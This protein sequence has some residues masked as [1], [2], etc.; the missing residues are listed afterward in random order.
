METAKNSWRKQ[1]NRKKER[2][3][4]TECTRR[5]KES[6]RYEEKRIEGEDQ[7]TKEMERRRE[8]EKKREKVKGK[9]ERRMGTGTEWKTAKT[10]NPNTVL[11]NW[12]SNGRFGD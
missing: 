2:N 7:K 4:P 1:E 3:I 8:E 5:D 11:T 10:P 12:N 9:E 6:E